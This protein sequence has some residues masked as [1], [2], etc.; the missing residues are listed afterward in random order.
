MSSDLASVLGSWTAVTSV[1]R[2][3]VT[4]IRTC[5][6]PYGVCVTVPANMPW[7]RP[8][9]P[10]G[11]TGGALRPDRDAAPAVGLAVGSPVDPAV[12]PPA[13]PAA[14]APLGSSGPAA[15]LSACALGSP[16]LIP[17]RATVPTAVP[18]MAT[19]A[20]RIVTS[21]G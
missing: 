1:S 6:G 7:C 8:V 18:M 12:P 4:V 17:T 9:P 5:T 16:A 14:D 19:I 15:V 11:G 3:P 10:A 21:R 13:P 20:R 2:P